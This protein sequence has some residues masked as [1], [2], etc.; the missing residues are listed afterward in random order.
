MYTIPEDYFGLTI[1]EFAAKIDFEDDLIN[2][3]GRISDNFR[4]ETLLYVVTHNTVGKV[5]KRAH[6]VMGQAR[7]K[8]K[9]THMVMTA[10][11]VSSFYA[12][13]DTFR[14]E[15]AHILDYFD[16]GTTNHDKHWRRW[17]TL[18]G[19]TPRA[20]SDDPVF[21][22]AAKRLAPKKKVIARCV[23]CGQEW[24]RA[25]RTDFSGCTHPKC[26][27]KVFNVFPS[28][29]EAERFGHYRFSSGFIGETFYR[30][31]F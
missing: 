20:T 25:R 8:G 18:C 7:C 9:Q 10:L 4:Q 27:G 13:T 22:E 5:E 31:M 30:E 2:L 15:V 1:A 23:E 12:M 29:A 11:P 17:A 28:R 16:R 26:G 3:I 19:A 6:S 21:A 14:H 24:S